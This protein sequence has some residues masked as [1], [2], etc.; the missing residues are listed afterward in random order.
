MLKHASV[1]FLV[2]AAIAATQAPAQSVPAAESKPAPAQIIE[3]YVEAIGG[4]AAIEK[5]T[6]RVMKGQTEIAGDET[7]TGTIEI[8]AKAPDKLVL[9]I[10]LPQNG[11]LASGYDGKTAWDI[12]PDYG[13]REL[14]DE[15]LA[16]VRRNADFYWPVKLAE[17]YPTMTVLGKEF[18]GPREAWVVQATPA[19]GD[20]DKLYFD[21]QTGLLLRKVEDVWDPDGKSTFQVDFSD[22]REVDGVKLP[23]VVRRGSDDFTMTIT[24]AEIRHNVPVP[25]SLFKKPAA[26]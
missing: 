18:A 22:Y 24:L 17:L 4:R 23:F 16:W 3:K 10:T 19:H 20:S 8:A 21:T 26:E 6:S 2:F 9:R 7:I 12:S 15:E 11:K 25:D 14:K 13:L 5:I 1:F